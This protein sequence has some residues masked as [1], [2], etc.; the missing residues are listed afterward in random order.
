[1]IPPVLAGLFGL[2]GR[3]WCSSRGRRASFSP[4]LWWG[5][6]MLGWVAKEVLPE[7]A[8]RAE[9]CAGIYLR[10]GTERGQQ[11]GQRGGQ[12]WAQHR[13]GHYQWRGRGGRALT[14]KL[15]EWL[16]RVDAAKRALGIAAPRGCLLSR[17]VQIPAGM[18]V[19][20]TA[21][22]MR[23]LTKFG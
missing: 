22:S 9:R 23:W 11:P 12:Y 18:A 10:V 6:A 21:E 7:A 16:Q 3:L 1:M 5:A 13:A 14:S 2:A 19:G 15:R 8:G 17:L 4:R 20:I